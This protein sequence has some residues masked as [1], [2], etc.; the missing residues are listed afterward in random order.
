MN[1]ILT[2]EQKR[3][4]SRQIISPSIGEEGQEK[5]SNISVLQIGA[6]GLGSPCSIYLTVAGIKKLTII[7]NDILE[8]SNL[9]RQILYNETQVGKN[10]ADLTKEVLSN[11][12]SE[13][14]IITYK[15]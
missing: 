11:L 3:R 6:G 4:Y 12:N 9:Q 15:D 13:V 1:F 5:L 14:Q 7:D 10:K 2:E 8:I